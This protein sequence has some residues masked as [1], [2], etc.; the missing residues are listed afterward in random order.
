M[1]SQQRPSPRHFLF[2]T[3]QHTPDDLN[4][5]LEGLAHV[6]KLPNTIDGQAVALAKVYSSYDPKITW[7]ALASLGYV[8]D[9]LLLD[10]QDAEHLP[11]GRI[12]V[13]FYQPLLEEE[14]QDFAAQNQLSVFKRNK[15]VPEQVAFERLEPQHSFLPD[16]IEKI[17]HSQKVRAAWADTLSLYQRI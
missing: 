1:L 15:Y 10:E 16:V 6:E 17:T 9:P 12:S 3:G 2:R 8:A 11:T 4:H 13:R 7:Q 5:D 14:L